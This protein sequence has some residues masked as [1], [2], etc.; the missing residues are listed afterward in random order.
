MH[1]TR[2]DVLAADQLGWAVHPHA[3]E[4]EGGTFNPLKFQ[5]LD[6]RALTFYREWELSTNNAVA[7]LRAAA[8]RDPG[9][10]G[11]IQLVGELSTHSERFRQ[12]RACSHNVLRSR[13]GVKRYR[14]PLVGE[15]D[16]DFASFDVSGEP[17]LRGQA[18]DTTTH[19]Q[20][21]WE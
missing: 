10:E 13:E 14:H 11:I 19:H 8:G 5:L 16:F 12:L 15:I 6:P 2:L 4:A 17:G 20:S 3:Q 18:F 21:R 7:L 9:D 1:D